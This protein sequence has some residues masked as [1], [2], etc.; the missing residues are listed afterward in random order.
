MRV[1]RSPRRRFVPSSTAGEA[2]G[3]HDSSSVVGTLGWAPG[4]R[5]DPASGAVSAASDAGLACYPHLVVLLTTELDTE[6]TGPGS[7]R[8]AHADL[9]LFIRRER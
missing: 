3:A 6:G 8:L 9:P 7:R 4:A 1:S 2:V 5:R